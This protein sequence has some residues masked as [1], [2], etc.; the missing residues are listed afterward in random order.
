MSRMAIAQPIDVALHGSAERYG[1]LC[2]HAIVDARRSFSHA[3]VFEAVRA[4]VAAFP[5]LDCVYKPRFF[6]DL[7]IRAKA[8]LSDTVHVGDTGDLEAETQRWTQRHIDPTRERSLRVVLFPSGSGTRLVV[9]LSHLAVDGAGMAAVGHVFASHLHGVPPSLPVEPRR[10]LRR[11]Q[12]GLQIQHLPVLARDMART[13]LQHYRVLS[14]APRERP[15]PV[16]GSP[17][18]S[19]R[20][21]VFEAA[22]IEAIRA[23][24]GPGTSVN[25]LLVAV[26]ARMGAQRSSEGPVAVLYTMDLR[27]FSRA[28][29]LSAANA[30]TILTTV[31][32]RAA[33]ATLQDTVKAVR[34]LTARHR[35]SLLGPAFLL[36]PVA[37]VGAAPHALIR[38][39]LPWIHPVLIDLPLRRGLI[40]TN[41]G[42]LDHGLGP[43]A[44]GIDSIR[45]VGPNVRGVD[46]P[47]IIAFGHKGRVHLELFAP[48]GLGEEALNELETELRQALH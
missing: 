13:V 3:E 37:L 2:V 15:Y 43:F 5:V 44:E 23:R 48:P 6:R 10:D 41:V 25:D 21:L 40:F 20:H 33:T 46:V 12:D 26:L 42:R 19:T 8:P 32:P 18:A 39:V 38:R 35:N 36:L 34:E 1:D 29:H 11:A 24:C 22:E 45:V 16:D 31:V 30:S 28:P 9:S 7:W 17:V 4:T 27:R 47:A 14:A